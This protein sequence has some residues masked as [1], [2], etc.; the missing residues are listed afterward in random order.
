MTVVSI[1]S[2]GAI[3]RAAARVFLG[4]GEARDPL[5]SPEPDESREV[6]HEPRKRPA[7]MLVPAAALVVAALGLSL[8]PGLEQG[9]EQQAARFQDRA[10]YAQTVFAQQPSAVH[11]PPL[12]SALPTFTASS[13]A[14]GV[15]SAAG[16]VLVALLGLY[17]PRLARR[18]PSGPLRAVSVSIGPLRAAHSGLVTDYVTWVVVGTAALGGIFAVTLVS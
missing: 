6:E 5:L 9:L 7:V 4:W 17:R 1:V 10:A 18:L 11:A 14:Y 8:V 15:A 3:L 12:G 16:A 2:V 13:V